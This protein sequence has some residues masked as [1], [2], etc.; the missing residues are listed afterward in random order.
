MNVTIIVFERLSSTCWN[1]KL[2][3]PTI[4]MSRVTFNVIAQNQILFLFQLQILFKNFKCDSK[5][6]LFCK[7]MRINPN[8]DKHDM[9]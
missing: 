2:Q 4:V 3:P 1:E 9:I 8:V 7:Q 6:T 5:A